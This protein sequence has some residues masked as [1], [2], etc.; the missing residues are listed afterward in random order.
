MNFQ[1]SVCTTEPRP[2][3][4]ENMMYVFSNEQDALDFIRTSGKEFTAAAKRQSG[5]QLLGGPAG[6]RVGYHWQQWEAGEEAIH[7]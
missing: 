3:S 4:E 6:M 2:R 7:E 5:T 1:Y